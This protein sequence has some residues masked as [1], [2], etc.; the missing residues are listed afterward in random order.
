MLGLGADVAAFVDPSTAT[1]VRGQMHCT[2][3]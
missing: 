3:C 2:G 1:D